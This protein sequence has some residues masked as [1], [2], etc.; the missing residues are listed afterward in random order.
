MG[1]KENMGKTQFVATTSKGKREMQQELGEEDGD[2]LKDEL[3]VLGTHS[4]SAR[5]RK[6]L[7]KEQQRLEEAA[8][9]V[10]LVGI[11]P[12][13]W[14]AKAQYIRAFGAGWLGHQPRLTW[15]ASSVLSGKR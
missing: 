1:L 9:T 3:H 8:A 5:Q 11:L 12:I 10:D 15:I 6:T 2:F 13:G 14:G 4:V 7:P